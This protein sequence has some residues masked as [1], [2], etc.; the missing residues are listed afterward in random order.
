MIYLIGIPGLIPFYLCFYS[1]DLIFLDFNKQMFVYYSAVI[2]SFLG[3]VY[4]GVF[5]HSKNVIAIL[6]SVCPSVYAFFVL[7]F[8]LKFDETV[9]LFV[10]GYFIV[11]CFDFFF[12][13]K[14]KNH[15]NRLFYFKTIADCWNSASTYLIYYLKI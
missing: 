11:L 4:W 15:P 2:L 12:Y 1:I 5:L 13:F 14:E 8:D 10:L 7:S 3:A 9:G 6:F